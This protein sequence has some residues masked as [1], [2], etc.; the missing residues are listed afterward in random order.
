VSRPCAGSL[1]LMY[2][3]TDVDVDVAEW[4]DEPLVVDG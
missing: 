2:D 3:A 4:R 1:D